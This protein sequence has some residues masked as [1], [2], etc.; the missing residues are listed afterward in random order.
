MYQLSSSQSSAAQ[1]QASQSQRISSSGERSSAAKARTARCS[2]TARCRVAAREP[3]RQPVQEQIGRSRGLGRLRGVAR[4]PGNLEGG[5]A[6][7]KAAREHGGGER[8]EIG[9]AGE[10]RVEAFE[11]RG[12]L[13][14][15]R[16]GFVAPVDGERDLGLE[17]VG[18]G[19]LEIGERPG[20]RR[21]EQRASGVGGAG[22][23]L[24]LGRRQAAGAAL[25]RV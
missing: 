5:G 22:R 9:V 1:T 23:Q 12:G 3:D 19:V 16:G 24:C 20:S 6:T 15:E 2:G 18:A 14:Q 8:F 7:G 25:V 17:Q 10:C 21:A 11:L 13:E 4:G